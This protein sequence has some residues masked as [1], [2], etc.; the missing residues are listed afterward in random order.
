MID[1][2][3]FEAICDEIYDEIVLTF[4]GNYTVKRT[5][6]DIITLT[7]NDSIVS[8]YIE[9]RDRRTFDDKLNDIA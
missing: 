3:L 7:H 9:A 2:V 4:G 5:S 6:K 1:N 8:K